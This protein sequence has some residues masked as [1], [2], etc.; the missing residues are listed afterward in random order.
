ME[1][2]REVARGDGDIAVGI[3]GF[4]S[5]KVGAERWHE[6]ADLTGRTTYYLQYDAQQLPWADD[7]DP[8]DM[9]TVYWDVLERWKKAR[10]GAMAASGY[11]AKWLTRWAKAGR[12]ILVVGFSLG[13][14]TGWLAVQQVPDDL[15]PQIE[16]VMVSAAIGD[17]V[18]TWRGLEKVS[19]V[20]N[21]FSS[22]DAALA[23]VYP[24][25]VDTDE[26][27]AAGLGPLVVS[28]LPNLRNI[29]ITDI[30]GWDH[31]RASKMLPRIMKIA[32][33]C[34]WGLRGVPSVYCVPLEVPSSVPLSSDEVSRLLRWT[35]VD[36]SLWRIL[37]TAMDGDPISV[38]R[39]RVLDSWSLRDHRLLSLLDAGAAVETLSSSKVAMAT[40]ERSRQVL[41]GVVRHWVSKSSELQGLG[42]FNPPGL[43]SGKSDAL[44]PSLEVE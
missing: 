16:L 19:S 44:A 42:E 3:S 34:M 27:P 39:M 8:P 6:L 15:K 17:R 10:A 31:L 14:Y 26:T 12:K 29:D 25:G 13:A 28:P 20:V 36:A 5:A 1:S 38:H 24:R 23:Y 2:L 32:M 22:K 9:A 7:E 11:L 40:A 30:V 4:G 33:G 41:S 18:S 43:S 35:L 21:L 37:A